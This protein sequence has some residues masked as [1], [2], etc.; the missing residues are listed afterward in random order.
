MGIQ[1]RSK[2]LAFVMA[3]GKG[4]RL[5]PLTADRAK[6]AVPF[7]GKY[8]IIDFVLSNLINSGIYSVYVLTQFKSQ[9]L[10]EHLQEGWNLGGAIPGHFV[11]G[12]P[13]QQ[14]HGEFWYRGTADCIYQNL[15]LI[16]DRRPDQVVVFGGD[17]IFL[18]NID[19]MLG[20]HR[21][22][23]AEATI[24]C[25]PC[26]IGEAS[27]FGV[28]QVDADWKIV[29]F[30]E[31][32]AQPTPIPGKPDQALVS[33][34][35]YVFSP[36]ALERYLLRDA[37]DARSDHDFGKN[38]LPTMLAEGR[39]LYAYDF[40]RNEI[41]G[42]HKESNP[43]YW[44]DVGTLDAYFDAAMDLRAVH[45]QL[46]LYNKEWPIRT[47]SSELPPPKFVHNVEGRVGQ[48]IQS[49]VCDG[50][51]ISGATVIDS[52]IGSECRVN[53]FSEVNQCVLLDDVQV[54]R[55]ARLFRCII[56]K[57]VI[58]PP[59]ERIGFDPELDRK[60]FAVTENGI[61]VIGKHQKIS[62]LPA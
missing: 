54:G 15:N 43:S 58:I 49:V 30:Q 48:A 25:I 5:E 8:R 50:T 24:A 13:A 44:R 55:G 52:I 28:V 34:G 9:S 10:S 4:T 62:P 33:M 38:V 23:R 39:A 21:A 32:P 2:V 51:I 22:K 14:R 29:G 59:G 12:V 19:H 16:Q 37:E 53:S 60:R 31:K 11:L 17:H 1:T 3:G 36:E 47:A 45:P 7:G 20:F 41:P 46:D 35:N 27:R 57:H 40:G 18:M 6:P 56:D 61:V 26:P 42:R